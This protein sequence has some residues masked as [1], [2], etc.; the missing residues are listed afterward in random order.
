MCPGMIPAL[1]LPGEMAPGAVRTHEPG[2]RAIFQERERA[3]HVKRGDAFRDAD[4]QPQSCLGRFH[5]RI[6]R[7]G[8]RHEDDRR[9]GARRIHGVGDRIENRPPF[10]CRPALARRDASNHGGA[11][12]L[13]LL[14]VKGA[15][16]AGEALDE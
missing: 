4:H 3:H 14:G 12:R 13:R 5:H 10:M 11:I 2:I 7:K 6:G 9:V 16:F 8:R 15:F 1:A